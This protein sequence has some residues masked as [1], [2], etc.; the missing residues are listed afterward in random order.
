MRRFGRSKRRMM[1]LAAREG[2][3]AN[4]APISRPNLAPLA[5]I[6][7][8]AST[9]LAAVYINP[10]HA[11]L[12][13]LPPFYP[14]DYLGPLTPNVNLLSITPDGA[15]LWNNSRISTVQLREV[16][17]QTRVAPEQP[18]LLF[19]PD[20]AATYGAAANVLN[21]LH[22]E[23]AIDRCFLFDDI[24]KFR[25]FESDEVETGPTPNSPRI[26]NVYY[27]F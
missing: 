3:S 1:H 22:D 25:R 15:I 8:V 20:G 16:L 21:I 11:I 27:G 23:G 10:P 19:R 9:A 12:V 13:E 14:D 2:R 24:A 7:M 17:R 26:C 4:F 5:A 6:W 18:A